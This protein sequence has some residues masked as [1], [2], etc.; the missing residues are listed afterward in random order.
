MANYPSDPHPHLPPSANI[1]PHCI[2][3]RRRAFHVFS[4]T[5]LLNC[6][7]W[8]IVILE[9]EIDLSQFASDADLI[10][11]FLNKQGYHVHQMS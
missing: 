4:N 10:R 11:A 7:D 1:V 6:D 9:P 5:P 3:R 8:A 2:H